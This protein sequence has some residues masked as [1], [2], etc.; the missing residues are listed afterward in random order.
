MKK[1]FGTEVNN[2]PVMDKGFFKKRVQS[3]RQ[4]LVI[5]TKFLIWI[6]VCINRNDTHIINERIDNDTHIIKNERLEGCMD[7][8][9]L[10]LH[11]KRIRLK[12]YIQVIS[13]KALVINKCR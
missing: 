11:A 6:S 3:S 5:C 4:K 2:N 8:C 7:G 13:L 12:F 10:C 9:L 1:K